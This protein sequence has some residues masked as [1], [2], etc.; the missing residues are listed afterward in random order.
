MPLFNFGSVCFHPTDIARTVYRS[1]QP[2]ADGFEFLRDFLAVRTVVKLNLEHEHSL[3]DECR[4]FGVGPERPG[5]AVLYEGMPEF[6]RENETDH[7][8]KIIK[9]IRTQIRD[10]QGGVLIHCA[11]GTDRTGVVSA[12]YQMAYG[13]VTLQ[14]ALH[15]RKLYGVGAL[16]DIFDMFDHPVLTNIARRAAAGEFKDG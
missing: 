11:M 2:D 7:V 4:D 15:E 9:T 16:R 5:I 10:V 14:Q 3:A 1:A 8:V 13:G 12:C 6:F